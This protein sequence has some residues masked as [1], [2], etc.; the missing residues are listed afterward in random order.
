MKASLLVI[1]DLH[2]GGAPADPVQG[3]PSFQICSAEGQQRLVQFIQWATTR[4]TDTHDVHLVLA[5]DIV[6]FLAEVDA[7]EGPCAFNAKQSD[8]LRKLGDPGTSW[9]A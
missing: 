9:A 2:L 3:K 5:G 6:D 4:K 7:A 1:S 8:A